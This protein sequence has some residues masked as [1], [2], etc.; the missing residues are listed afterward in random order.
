M[1]QADWNRAMDKA[2]T[3]AEAA[4]LQ[5]IGLPKPFTFVAIVAWSGLCLYVG[6]AVK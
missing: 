4:L 3:L 1:K 2:E 5:I 6:Y